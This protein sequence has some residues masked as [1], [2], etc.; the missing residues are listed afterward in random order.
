MERAVYSADIF[1]LKILF[2]FNELIFRCNVGSGA[3]GYVFLLEKNNIET[4]D[5]IK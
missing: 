2:Y 1:N 4:N 5:T 3:N